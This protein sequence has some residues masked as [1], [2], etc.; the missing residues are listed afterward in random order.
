MNCPFNTT[1]PSFT[2]LKHA[3]DRTKAYVHHTPVMTCLTLDELSGA[4]LFFKCE[5]FQKA[6]A[7]KIRGAMNAILQL[8][9]EKKKNGV[10]THSSGNFAQALSLAARHAG[11]SAFIVMPENAPSVKIDAVRGYG[12]EIIFC[13]PTLEARELTLRQVVERTGACFVHPYNDMNVILGQGTAALEL[14]RE[15]KTLDVLIAPVGGGGLISGTAL[16]AHYLLPEAKIYAGEPM[17]ADDAWQS[18][19]QGRIITGSNP[20]TIADGLRTCLGDKT[21]PIIKT[22]LTDIIRVEEN[23]IVDAMKLVWERMKIIIEPS[24]AVAFAAVLKEKERFRGK[25]TGVILSGGNIDI[26]G[27]FKTFQS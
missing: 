19:H 25:R 23:E 9:S 22:L 18:F 10:A 24:S 17:A 11:I 20:K 27:F 8:S 1:L 16:A 3:A 21:Y 6:G 7:F 15:V 26:S 13:T 2:D 12:A 14:I 5:N 4:E